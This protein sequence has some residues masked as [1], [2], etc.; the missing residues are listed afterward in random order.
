MAEST[1]RRLMGDRPSRPTPKHAL[2]S[3]GGSGASKLLSFASAE[4]C[5]EMERRRLLVRCPS[6]Q[7]IHKS[8]SMNEFSSMNESFSESCLMKIPRSAQKP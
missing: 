4:E 2:T 6:S 1:A 3:S 5:F 7:L 8:F